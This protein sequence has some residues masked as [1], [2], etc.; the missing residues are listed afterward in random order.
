[1]WPVCIHIA[2]LTIEGLDLKTPEMKTEKC[3][4]KHGG[5]GGVGGEDYTRGDDMCV[6]VFD[7]FNSP[8]WRCS[9]HAPLRHPSLRI[10]LLLPADVLFGSR[11]LSTSRCQ[12]GRGRR[13]QSGRAESTAGCNTPHPPNGGLQVSPVSLDCAVW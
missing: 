1:M 6:C 2:N 9:H 3:G 13:R 8:A 5:G 4:F 12:E 7:T 11:R 10:R